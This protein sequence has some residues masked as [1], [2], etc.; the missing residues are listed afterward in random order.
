MTKAGG[1][2]PSQTW[3]TRNGYSGLVAAIQ[4][5]P[6]AFAHIR[7]NWKGGQTPEE[8]VPVAESLAAQHGDIL[9][10]RHWLVASGYHGLVYAM[11]RKPEAFAHIQQAK[12]RH[13]RDHWVA[14]AE[15]LATKHGGRLPC[16][17]WLRR[18]DY[19][20]LA[21]A[22]TRL[23]ALFA[24]I[25]RETSRG[26]TPME[27]VAVAEDLA[28]THGG[29][30]P[31]CGWLISSGYGALY[32]AKKGSPALF[33]HIPSSSKKGHT[34]EEWLLIAEHLAAQHNGALPNAAWLAKNGHAGLCRALVGRPELF[35]HI[36]ALDQENPNDRELAACSRRTSRSI[37]WKAPAAKVASCQW[38]RT[39]SDSHAK[40]SRAF[41]SR[42]TGQ[43]NPYEG[44]MGLIRGELGH[45]TWP[46]PA[47]SRSA[48][49]KSRGTLPRH[50]A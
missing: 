47:C 29:A 30:L 1:I 33:A 5:H 21:D 26:R 22:L 20:P 14:V 8:W 4:K 6:A 50:V 43:T 48:Q 41:C 19:A 37:W 9:P 2:L 17:S 7:Q 28:A 3:L 12:K 23:P 25:P 45:R 46:H 27:W 10:Y 40:A 13:S 49:A 38:P 36:T 15:K 39:V 35:V 42:S 44:Q 34:P 11:R 16:P 24:H 18:N 32:N 31:N